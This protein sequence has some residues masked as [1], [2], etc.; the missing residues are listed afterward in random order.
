M[1]IFITNEDILRTNE[2]LIKGEKVTL[3]RSEEE[4][5]RKIKQTITPFEELPQVKAELERVRKIQASY[6]YA[7]ATV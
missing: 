7:C 1:P 5:F 4:L 2:R 6:P 3:S